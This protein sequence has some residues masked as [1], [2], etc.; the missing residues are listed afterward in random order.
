MTA[1][2]KS[3]LLP[4]LIGL[5]KLVSP[6]ACGLKS[7]TNDISVLYIAWFR[8]FLFSVCFKMD[9]V[10]RETKIKKKN[11]NWRS[12]LPFIFWEPHQEGKKPRYLEESTFQGF[13]LSHQVPKRNALL[14]QYGKRKV[15]GQ[16][17]RPVTEI[18][19]SHRLQISFRFSKRTRRKQSSASVPCQI[20]ICNNHPIEGKIYRKGNVR[21]VVEEEKCWTVELCYVMN[22]VYL[23]QVLHSSS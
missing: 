18:G 19:N 4:I 22:R 23:S 10:T 3:S 17:Q 12:P 2:C 20:F 9:H 5:N 7:L 1:R 14:K 16:W 11:S 21:L 13:L 6:K 15:I 8:C